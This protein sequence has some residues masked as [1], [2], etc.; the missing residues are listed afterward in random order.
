M[1]ETAVRLPVTFH[2]LWSLGIGETK[3]DDFSVWFQGTVA[4]TGKMI[5]TR[6]DQDHLQ[7]NLNPVSPAWAAESRKLI[8]LIERSGQTYHTISKMN[9]RENVPAKAG[10]LDPSNAHSVSPP[11]GSV[12]KG[13]ALSL[14]VLV[15]P[16]VSGDLGRV[17][18]KLDSIARLNLEFNYLKIGGQP[19]LGLRSSMAMGSTISNNQIRIYGGPEIGVYAPWTALPHQINLC[20]SLGGL[21][22]VE[23][24]LSETTSVYFE[25]GG[26][27]GY[28]GYAADLTPLFDSYIRGGL[29]LVRF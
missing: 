20:A 8:Y 22:G 1:S 27:Y 29:T 6:P 7:I 26:G 25:F 23:F 14:G 4:C 2:D 21:G 24:K 13:T 18:F 16:N 3:S 5:V 15:L 28:N 19:S 10:A 11:N 17:Q 9:D 12:E